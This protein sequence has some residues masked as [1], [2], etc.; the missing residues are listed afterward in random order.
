MNLEEIKAKAERTL[1]VNINVAVYSANET[2]LK[3]VSALE[4]AIAQ[5][6]ENL[7]YSDSLTFDQMESIC[8]EDNKVIMEILNGT[9]KTV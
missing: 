5:R 9:N 4:K 1:A 3:L 8:N 7:N 2:I 6:D